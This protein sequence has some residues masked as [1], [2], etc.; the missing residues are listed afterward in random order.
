MT[1][2]EMT[3]KLKPMVGGFFLKVYINKKTGAIEYIES[4]PRIYEENEWI[5]EAGLE[6]D[7]I[8]Q[9]RR[10]LIKK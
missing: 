8:I 9:K 3:H 10:K 7:E 4:D 5:D 2:F 1:N 6:L